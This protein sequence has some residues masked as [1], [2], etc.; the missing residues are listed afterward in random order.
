MEFKSYNK[1]LDPVIESLKAISIIGIVI[2]TINNKFL[3][4]G[5]LGIDIF[6]FLTGYLSIPSLRKKR[7]QI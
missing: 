4:G 2:N 6:F 1:T 3:P 7:I 5:Y